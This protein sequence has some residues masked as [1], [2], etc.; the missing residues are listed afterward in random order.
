MK[1]ASEPEEAAML[2]RWV[3]WT[4]AVLAAVLAGSG[5]A[6][7]QDS[8]EVQAA[9]EVWVKA[10]GHRVYY[11]NKFDLSDLPAYVPEAK[12]S[13]TIRMWG[14]NY[15]TDSP[16]AEWWADEFR[17]H[18]PD[19]K[20]DFHLNTTLHAIP[21]LIFGVSAIGPMGPTILVIELLGFMRWLRHLQL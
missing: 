17:K 18:H 8:V 11:T 13:G 7:N 21:G 10:K 1:S 12:V 20:F 3:G 6:A 4:V 2:N 19:V 16:L 15:L 9:R 5:L 14:S